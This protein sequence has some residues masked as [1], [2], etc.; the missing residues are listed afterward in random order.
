[1]EARGLNGVTVWLT[2][3][4][5]VFSMETVFPKEYIPTL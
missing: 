3:I 5:I 1:M 2:I 4:I